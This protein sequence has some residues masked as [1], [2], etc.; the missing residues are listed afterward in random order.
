MSENGNG[1]VLYWENFLAGDKEA[2]A[3]IYSM[4]VESMYRYGTKLCNDEN[5]VKDAIQEIFLELFL[6]RHKNKTNP[7][8]LRYYLIL[9]LKHNLI[10]KLKRNRRQIEG[11]DSNLVFEPEYSIENIIIENETEAEINHRIHNLLQKLPAK[12][13]EVLYL[14]FNESMEYSEIAQLLNISVKSAHK[15]VYR[16]LKSIR[17]K[18]EN[19][20]I[21]VLFTAGGT[22]GKQEL[23]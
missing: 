23:F 16:A 6:K 20:K 1:T 14:R 21:V 13:K 2:F 11:E 3:Y 10:K 8:N 15:Q 19:Q 7:G 18:I 4:H 12:Q 5:L 22:R 9:A 17:K